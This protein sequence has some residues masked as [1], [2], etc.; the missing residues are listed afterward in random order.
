MSVASNEAASQRL[1]VD[2]AL[3]PEMNPGP[4]CRMTREGMILLANSKAKSF[5][6]DEHL[7]GKNW[8][9]LLSVLDDSTW[10]NILASEHPYAVEEKIADVWMS[11]AHVISPARDQL[12]VYGTDITHN[13]QIEQQIAEIAR[14]PDMNPGP[15]LRL[16]L[17][18]EVLLF[19]AAA[20]NVFGGDQTGKN[21]KQICPGL[22]E[23][24]WK[25]ITES[26]ELE[27]V[28]AKVGQK[29][30][31]FNHRLDFRTNVV[32]V[33]GAD[34]TENKLAEQKL[35]EQA[36]QI[37]EIARFPDMNPGPVL[38]T[39]P[40]G[41]I[42]LSNAAATNVFG[43][44]LV[45]Q[46]W[47]KTCPGLKQSQWNDILASS[48]VVPIEARVGQKDFVFHH[49]RDFKT[50]L[51]FI[52]GSDVTLQKLA[53][54]QLRQ[55][56]KMATLGTLAAGVAHE[57]NNPA[58]AVR[59]SALLLKEAFQKLREIYTVLTESNPTAQDMDIINA[60]EDRIEKSA[61]QQIALDSIQRSDLEN[62][63]EEWMDEHDVADAWHVAPLLVG[64]GFTVSDLGELGDRLSLQAVAP[65]IAW[66]AALQPVF[67]LMYEIA[68]GSSRIS[69]IVVAMKG[70]SYLGQAPVQNV[71]IHE[72]IDNTLVILRSKL[73]TGI[74][75]NREYAPNL[76]AIT[77]YGSE[78]N[79]V[80]TNILDNAADAMQ[81][82][83]DITIRTKRVG[84]SVAVEIED[85][86]P[87]IPED[88]QSQI[89]DPFFTTKPPGKGT[90]LGLATTYGI[91]TEKHKGRINV[92]S[93]PGST[94]FQVLLPIHGVDTQS[95]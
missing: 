51:V 18:G 38:R 12:F 6:G 72:G 25:Q 93:R 46:N 14:F 73:K 15:V 77:A 85:T 76:P 16:T 95:I 57:L 49:R 4:V 66:L 29:T 88:V 1:A 2:M 21:W 35:A 31:F 71:D 80:W 45:G 61:G 7:A 87:G 68:E 91:V 39:D 5:F 82:K 69:E 50:D 67:S 79:Q 27:R 13:K 41:C 84:D 52:F 32:F 8:R 56:E 43:E 22:T 44:N 63:M 74:N 92:N 54:R 59:R 24:R 23:A 94:V 60:L 3:F 86:G 36:E 34:I 89:F 53:E 78:L 81:G 30:W 11:F 62:E 55:S 40:D 65:A 20:S 64:S 75:V 28:E 37:A 9:S 70:Y 17:D 83:G 19:N 10:Q 33:Y 42:L 48:E 90:G 47:L 58:A 26:S